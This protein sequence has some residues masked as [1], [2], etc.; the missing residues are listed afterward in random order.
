M[1]LI[2]QFSSASVEN[3]VLACV[4]DGERLREVCFSPDGTAVAFITSK[5][6]EHWVRNANG[7]RAAYADARNLVVG[8]C[9]ETTACVARLG[10]NALV[11]IN[12][13]YQQTFRWAS[14]PVLSPDGIQTAY[15]GELSPGDNSHTPAGGSFYVVV[16]DQTRGPYESHGHMFF[17]PLDGRLVYTIQERGDS[18]VACGAEEGPRFDRVLR[19]EI[20]VCDG[21]VWYWA[22][23][24]PKWLIVRNHE[25]IDTSDKC[26]MPYGPFFWSN[27]N[28]V[29][30]WKCGETN[31]SLMLNGQ[32][33][34]TAQTPVGMINSIDVTDSGQVAYAFQSDGGVWISAAGEK[35]GPFDAVGAPTFSPDGRRLAYMAR[36]SYTSYLVLDGVPGEPFDAILPEE[37]DLSNY[38]EDIPVFR[39]DG[40]SVAYRA[41]R[42][43]SEYIVCDG[44]AGEPFGFV[45]GGPAFSPNNGHLVYAAGESL[46]EYVVVDHHRSEPFNRIWSPSPE[47]SLSMMWK[48]TFSADGNKVLFGAL[49]DGQ[50]LWRALSI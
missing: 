10:H 11:P 32:S 41:C 18:F 21:S 9:G 20:N 38:L 39:D 47:S 24:S 43:Q 5:D 22:Y 46:K 25:V 15:Y 27:G 7:T 12:G 40:L 37:G 19:P 48:P 42:G 36:R 33:V 49:S 17:N 35:Q 3:C 28:H 14:E 50:V 44:E 6:A 8:P 26:P 16:G 45:S 23:R 34:G 30:Y 29:A 4:A 1:P 13:A 2:S 31:W